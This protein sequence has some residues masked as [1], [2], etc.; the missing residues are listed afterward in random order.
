MFDTDE[1]N[2]TFGIDTYPEYDDQPQTSEQAHQN[3]EQLRAV[4]T[5]HLVHEQDRV[6]KEQI[7]RHPL[8]LALNAKFNGLIRDDR[9]ILMHRV[10]EAI[11]A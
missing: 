10:Q 8:E 2:Y 6:T 5:G 4:W 9:S 11:G 3:Q 7:R 1:T